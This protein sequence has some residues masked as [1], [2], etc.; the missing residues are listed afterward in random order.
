MSKPRFEESVATYCYQLLRVYCTTR[1]HVSED[2]I[3]HISAIKTSNLTPSPLQ[4]PAVIC[5]NHRKLTITLCGQDREFLNHKAGSFNLSLRLN[6]EALHRGE[7]QESRCILALQNILISSAKDSPV[8]FSFLLNSLAVR[9]FA[10]LLQEYTWRVSN[11][12]S[13][14]RLSRSNLATVCKNDDTIIIRLGADFFNSPVTEK[15]SV[16]FTQ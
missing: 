11:H 2:T 3:P 16:I 12:F 1:R 13:K 9:M 10:N 7:L 5:E 14:L 6:N 8:P 4:N 15:K